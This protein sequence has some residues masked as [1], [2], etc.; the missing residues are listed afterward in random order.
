[1]S[2]FKKT[3]IQ[4]F[5]KGSVVT[6]EDCEYW[7]QLGVSLIKSLINEFQYFLDIFR[8]Y[9]NLTI[10]FRNKLLSKNLDPLTMLTS[11][12]SRLTTLP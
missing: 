1:M 7:K 11:V 5:T 9:L 2:S 4:T 10:L 8:T 12:R 3:P 6:N